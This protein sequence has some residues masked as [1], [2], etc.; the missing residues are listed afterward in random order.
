[1][2]DK[3]SY[4]DSIANNS[5]IHEIIFIGLVVLCFTGDIIGEVS[6]HAAIIYWLTMV[7]LFFLS[8]LI[9]DKAQ[10]LKSKKT[11]NLQF[12]ITLWSSAF[13]AL[14]LILLL[15]HSGAFLAASVGI[16][17]HIILAHTVFITGVALGLRFY[18]IGL[19]L[20]ILAGLTIAM[21]GAVGI[22]LLLSI[23]II[24]V[25]LYVKKNIMQNLN[26]ENPI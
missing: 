2:T 6:D 10:S 14:L 1:M 3:K 20:F 7:P 26:K 8:T 21:E 22:T 23:P 4:L 5:Y 11:K 19:F 16:I 13:F 12:I 25:G 24:I 17:V 15:W 18:L 9:I